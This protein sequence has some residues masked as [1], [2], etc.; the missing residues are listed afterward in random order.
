MT[1]LKFV[2]LGLGWIGDRGGGLERYQH[3]ICTAHARL[4]CDVTAWVQSRTEIVDEFDYKAI[5]FASP[6]EKRLRKLRS[7]GYLA[8]ERFGVRDFIFVSHH[9]SVGGCL[10]DLCRRVPHVVHFHGPWAD[11]ATIEGA[12]WWKTTLQRRQERLAYHSASRI[13]TLSRSFKQLVV[14]RYGVSES[15]VHV[16]P[17][18]IDAA[19]ADPGISRA[20]ARQQLGWPADRPI[21][22]AMRRLVKRVGVDVLVQAID[23]LIRDHK[24]ASDLLVMIGG[25]GP[26]QDDLK[27]CI[28][29]LGLQNN[30][31][32]LGFVPEEQLSTA[33]RAAD[34]SIVPTQSLEGFGLVTLESMAAGTPAI[35]TPVGSLPEV[36]SP[37]C[38]SLILGGTSASEIA[39]G[40]YAIVRGQVETPNDDVCRR[41]VRDNY[42]WSVIGPRVLEVYRSAC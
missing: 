26:M 36:I 31:R 16:V 15:L 13:I 20:E 24:S 25:T 12:P 29:D 38:N 19:M 7:L 28:N 18:A 11:E 1:R 35:V 10:V 14:E 42:D 33:Y 39:D 9:A 8:E 3:G 2:H 32:L 17:G 41:Y 5:A 34:F 21:V 40:L 27:K 30:V 37:L 22:L 23:R 4:G 6:V